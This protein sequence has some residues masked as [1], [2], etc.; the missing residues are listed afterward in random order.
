MKE[1][2]VL[3]SINMYT[4]YCTTSLTIGQYYSLND[5][6]RLLVLVYYYFFYFAVT[7]FVLMV[8]NNWYIIM[9]CK[10]TLWLAYLT[11]VLIASLHVGG[12]CLRGQSWLAGSS[13]LYK[14]LCCH[15]G[16]LASC[17]I[18]YCG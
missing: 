6:R 11:L 12:V 15:V 9:V 14:F 4:G 1:M 2:V 10:T 8:V 17:H 18:L 16:D 3:K 7:L 13:V 5:I